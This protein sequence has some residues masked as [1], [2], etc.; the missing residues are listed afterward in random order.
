MK[1]DNTQHT[2]GPWTMSDEYGSFI[3][4]GEKEAFEN[5]LDSKGTVCAVSF[6]GSY[7][8]NET[9]ANAHLIAAAPKM[10]EAL[11]AVRKWIGTHPAYDNI[12]TKINDAIAQAE[13]KQNQ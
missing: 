4:N 10:L 13:G 6:L 9:R 12:Q 11:K 3:G 7:R 8:L 1:T 2:P 5:H